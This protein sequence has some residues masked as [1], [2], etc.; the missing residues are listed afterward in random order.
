MTPKNISLIFMIALITFTAGCTSYLGDS[1]YKMHFFINE[2]GEPIDGNVYNNNNLLGYAE[3]GSLVTGIEKLRPGLI[4]IKGMY[5]DQPFE[6][7]FEFPRENLNYSGIE[8][9]LHQSDLMKA[10]FNASS[11]DIQRIEREIFDNINEERRA[12]GTNILRWNPQIATVARNYSKTLSVEGFAHKDLEGKSVG[13]RL[14]ENK[15]F[16]TIVAEDLYMLEGLSN[17]ENM[18]RTIVSGWMKSPGHRSPIVDRDRLFSDGGAG[19]YCEK[20]N[21]YAVMVFAGLE[22]DQNI[23]LDHGYLTFIYLYDP[24]FPFDFDVPVSINISSTEYIDVYLVS[25]REQYDNLLSNRNLNSIIE[26][27]QVRTFSRKVTARKGEGI[28]IQSVGSAAA[29]INVRLR[30]S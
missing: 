28:I 2:T 7:Y 9:S 20:K 21:C 11:L 26:S 15:I 27:K 18:S 3:N 10:L 5:N 6:F 13:D 29:D 8:F 24:S 23:K 19:I 22:H 12:A 4:S 17:E 16:Y 30:Y 25:G 14:K 1:S